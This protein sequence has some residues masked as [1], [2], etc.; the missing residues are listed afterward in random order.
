MSYSAAAARTGSW[1]RTAPAPCTAARPTMPLGGA[2]DD[3]LNGNAGRDAL[4]GGADRDTCNGGNGT[5]TGA[6]CETVTSIP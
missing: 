4:D 5:D 1:A 2:G 3:T 6:N